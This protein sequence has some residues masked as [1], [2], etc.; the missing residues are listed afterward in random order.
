MS[1]LT[2]ASR[3]L[4]LWALGIAF[5]PEEYGVYVI[6]ATVLR[7][8][9]QI[10]GL[11]LYTYMA[12]D[13]P[14]KPMLAG[15]TLL[16]TLLVFELA[17]AVLVIG[18]VVG[19]GL[20]HLLL[21][22]FQMDSYLWIFRFAAL[23]FLF[24][25]PFMEFVH[26]HYALKRIEV[27]NTMEFLASCSWVFPLVGLWMAGFPL[28]LSGLLTAWL[29][30]MVVGISYGVW[31]LER[32]AFGIAP[33]NR[34]LLKPALA[35]SL[36]IMFS[37]TGDRI[38]FLA[39]RW[40]LGFFH[41]PESVGQYGYAFALLSILWMLVYSVVVGVLVPYVVEADNMKKYRERDE[42]LAA[43]LKYSLLIVGY[44]LM[45]LVVFGDDIVRWMARQEYR[46]VGDLVLWLAPI[47]LL[48][49]ITA[50]A[51]HLLFIQKKTLLMTGISWTGAVTSLVMGILLIPIYGAVGAA[52]ATT[53]SLMLLT[54]LRYWAV[55]SEDTTKWR[56]S[57][58][59]EI[60][61]ACTLTGTLFFVL[62]RWMSSDGLVFLMA[63]ALAMGVIYG[64]LLFALGVVGPREWGVV[65]KWWTG[66]ATAQ[67]FGV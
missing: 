47:A 25:I 30:G 62:N 36:P 20:D 40:L 66:S 56:T 24:E 3:F 37:A 67:H 1:G 9:V 38:I 28:T 6:I 58:A 35:F 29:A 46:A 8:G 14:G 43:M 33:I 65:V 63:A 10:V 60:M 34:E 52:V 2:F 13:I 16:K 23:V 61:I 42:L 55:R 54:V 41:G 22:Q 7:F 4:L 49:T 31:Q 45:V 39:D 51:S 32:D 48:M 50:P 18:V 19:T 64:V 59:V 12:R 26:Y 53:L 5:I 15:M 57:R 17:L 44:G 11:Y 21:V 27:A